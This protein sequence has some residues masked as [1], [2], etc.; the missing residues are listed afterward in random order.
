MKSLRLVALSALLA[1][2]IVQP[3][4]SSTQCNAPADLQEGEIIR[5]WADPASVWLGDYDFDGNGIPDD[6]I[7]RWNPSGNVL[8]QYLSVR[9][10]FPGNIKTQVRY[11]IPRDGQHDD[12][13]Y[14]FA[15]S[16]THL[17]AQDEQPLY[18]I[19]FIVHGN[20]EVT[21]TPS[22]KTLDISDVAQRAEGLAPNQ[23]AWVEGNEL[24]VIPTE[25]FEAGPAGILW[26]RVKKWFK[27]LGPEPR[28]YSPHYEWE[29]GSTT[30]FRYVQMSTGWFKGTGGSLEYEGVALD[31]T[32]VNVQHLAF[33]GT[34][35]YDP[36]R[37]SWSETSNIDGYTWTRVHYWFSVPC[38]HFNIEIYK[39]NWAVKPN[40]DVVQIGKDH[41]GSEY[42]WPSCSVPNFN[43]PPRG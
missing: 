11:R 5:D 21:G 27:D 20:P 24:H 42:F 2:A 40:G 7:Y 6:I 15:Q 1:F 37:C 26:D 33:C 25:D 10:R 43:P 38:G 22:R 4:L 14:G 3:A 41:V 30:I 9:F 12:M 39:W 35:G 19:N 8:N 17:S 23:I 16:L 36:N 28:Y 13:I 32:T 29:P 34:I 18:G 31:G